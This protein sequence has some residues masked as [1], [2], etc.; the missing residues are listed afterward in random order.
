MANVV[1]LCHISTR[2]FC[3]LL[4]IIIHDLYFLSF[5]VKIW[6]DYENNDTKFREFLNHNFFL[7]TKIIRHNWSMKTLQ[8]V[9]VLFTI[10]EIFHFLLN[11]FLSTQPFLWLWIYILGRPMARLVLVNEK[12]KWR[13]SF[14]SLRLRTSSP[15]KGSEGKS[16]ANNSDNNECI[17]GTSFLWDYGKSLT[18][19]KL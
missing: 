12:G 10:F 14:H 19:M 18:L 8:S 5:C 4:K 15:P 6:C 11:L 1:W 9:S 13:L 3:V 7:I 16:P 2:N 17:G